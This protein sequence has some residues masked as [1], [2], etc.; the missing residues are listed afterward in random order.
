M[1][2]Q[3]RVPGVTLF[4]GRQKRDPVSDFGRAVDPPLKSDNL[5]T[6]ANY[7]CTHPDLMGSAGHHSYPKRVQLYF[8]YGRQS[9]HLHQ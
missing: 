4:R 9:I 8:W 6:S 7:A 1:H 3:L 5:S 2:L